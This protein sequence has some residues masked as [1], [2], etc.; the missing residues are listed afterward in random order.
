M[1]NVLGLGEGGGN[2]SIK[3]SSTTNLD[4][5]HKASFN[6]RTANFL[7][8]LLPVRAILSTKTCPFKLAVSFIT[9]IIPVSII[10]VVCIYVICSCDKHKTLHQNN[11]LRKQQ[12]VKFDYVCLQ[13]LILQCLVLIES[14]VDENDWCYLDDC[15]NRQHIQSSL[16][17]LCKVP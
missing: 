16:Q 9:Y 13:F 14:R 3:L 2:Q 7:N 12:Q 11:P 17:T 4:T 10:S 15:A 6:H 5:E 8:P 1:Y